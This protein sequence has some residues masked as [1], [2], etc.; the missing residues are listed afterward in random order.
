MAR[1]DAERLGGERTRERH[2]RQPDCRGQGG[3]DD[4]RDAARPSDPERV[5]RSAG[6]GPAV[7]RRSRDAEVHA[8]Y[9]GSARSDHSAGGPALSRLH[10][11]RTPRDRRPVDGRVSKPRNRPAHPKLFGYCWRTAAG[12]DPWGRSRPPRPSRR[13]RRGRDCW[14]TRP[15]RPSACKCC[16]SAADSRRPGCSRRDSGSSGC[17]RSAGSTPAGPTIR[18]RHVFSVWRSL[19]HESVPMLFRPRPGGGESR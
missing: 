13:R 8:L 9:S 6:G 16:F 18:S 1:R 11:S 17:C 14:R 3:S 15:E 4:R 10:R 12:S 2:P 19:L 7:R 5:G